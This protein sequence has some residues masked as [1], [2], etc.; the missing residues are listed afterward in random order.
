MYIHTYKMLEK[1]LNDILAQNALQTLS[2]L[3]LKSYKA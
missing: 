1:H 3:V 2:L